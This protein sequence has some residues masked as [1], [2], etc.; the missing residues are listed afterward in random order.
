MGMLGKPMTGTEAVAWSTAR[1][2]GTFSIGQL[3]AEAGVAVDTARK[4][5]RRWALA[6][7]VTR[8]GAQ[9]TLRYTARPEPTDLPPPRAQSPERN[10]WTAMR[11]IG[12]FSA[13][14]LALQ[15]S[16][17]SLGISEDMAGRYIRSLLPAGYL[18]V[19]QR[20]V[21]GRRPAVYRL[22]R[23]TGPLPPRECR[24]AAVWDANRGAWAHVPEVPR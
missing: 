24:I 15:A 3:S 10:M 16:T 13:R 22:I 9:K 14:D 1:R 12:A 6:G 19:V 18:R 21:P 17:D 20:A 8:A 5:L 7:L 2:L 11:K 4:Y 23:D